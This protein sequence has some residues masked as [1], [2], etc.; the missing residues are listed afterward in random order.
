M[1]KQLGNTTFYEPKEVAKVINKEYQT[2]LRRIDNGDI[3]AVRVGRIW[4]IS[5][6]SLVQFL[7]DFEALPESIIDLRLRRK[8]L[9]QYN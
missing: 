8:P 5:H 3:D 9:K 7:N 2:V 1:S 4:L 6:D